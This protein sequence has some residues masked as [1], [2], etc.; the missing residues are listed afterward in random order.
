MHAKTHRCVKWMQI[1]QRQVNRSMSMHSAHTHFPVYLKGVA[2]L[3]WDR[4]KKVSHCT[5]STCQQVGK[6]SPSLFVF[7]L[8]NYLNPRRIWEGFEG[9]MLSE[10]VVQRRHWQCLLKVKGNSFQSSLSQTVWPKLYGCVVSQLQKNGVSCAGALLCVPS[11][12][13]RPTL[14]HWGLVF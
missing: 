8:C 3:L 7:L 6:S 9:N 14:P 2:V 10:C 12:I 13:N 11:S 1:V 5:A 4:G